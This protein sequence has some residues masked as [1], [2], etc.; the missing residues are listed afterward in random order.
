MINR[1]NQVCAEAAAF[2]KNLQ[3]ADREEA[4]LRP[5]AMDLLRWLRCLWVLGIRWDQAT[6]VEARDFMRWMLLADK[7]VRL[8]WRRQR[9]QLAS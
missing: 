5:Y 9:Q 3:A 6:S 1:D 2:F 4:T 7:P 8:H